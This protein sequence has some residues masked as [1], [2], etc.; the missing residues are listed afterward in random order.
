MNI[1]IQVYFGVQAPI[2]IAARPP[3]SSKMAPLFSCTVPLTTAVLS[4]IY[5]NKGGGRRAYTA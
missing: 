5:V 4:C 3:E 2:S 1:T